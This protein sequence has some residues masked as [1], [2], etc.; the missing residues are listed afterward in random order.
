MK[1]MRRPLSEHL[2]HLLAQANRHVSRQLNADGVSFDQWRVMMAL[3]EEGGSTM[4]KL[5]EELAI[6]HPTLTKLIDRMAEEALVYRV[7]D[8]DDR[9]KVRMF[10]SDKG[11]A[12]LETQN[13]RV[14]LHEARVE[15][16]YGNEDVQKLRSML[17]TLIKQLS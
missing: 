7:P 13:Q 5:A 10:L 17:E 8:P 2:S 12:L 4:G 9:R 1:Y 6:N 15:D 11:T 14:Q 16:S 3:S